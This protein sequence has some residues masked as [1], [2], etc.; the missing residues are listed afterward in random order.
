MQEHIQMSH[1][2]ELMSR[3]DFFRKQKWDWRAEAVPVLKPSPLMPEFLHVATVQAKW[4]N[5]PEPLKGEG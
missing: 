3:E 5:E 4:S 1:Q 2:A